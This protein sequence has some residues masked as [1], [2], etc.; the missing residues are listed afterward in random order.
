MENINLIKDQI[1]AQVNIQDLYSKFQAIHTYLLIDQ[2][3]VELRFAIPKL[4]ISLS[5]LHNIIKVPFAEMI[6]IRKSLERNI[7]KN[8]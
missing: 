5:N 7:L 4:D 3:R 8:C 1:N 2:E 6:A